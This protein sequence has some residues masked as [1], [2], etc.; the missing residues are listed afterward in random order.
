MNSARSKAKSVR[1]KATTALLQ[2]GLLVVSLSLEL[3]GADGGALEILKSSKPDDVEG[4]SRTWIPKEIRGS[5]ASLDF[6]ELPIT[7]TY[8][9]AGKGAYRCRVSLI[10][11]CEGVAF[12]PIL[13]LYLLREAT[14]PEIVDVV[15][16]QHNLTEREHQ[17]LQGLAAGLSSHD[18]AQALAISPNTVK[19]FLQTIRVK[20]GAVNRGA[21]MS[22][23]LE[24]PLANRH[25]TIGEK[26]RGTSQG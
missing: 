21:I 14:V 6:S 16:H 2:E 9:V 10:K 12:E 11:P 15:A 5:L 23:L 20:M 24:N 26:A 7:V 17:V 18:I 8:I 3:L 19:S 4:D 22:R 1:V 13:A 25:I